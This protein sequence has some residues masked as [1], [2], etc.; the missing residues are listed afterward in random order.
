[1]ITHEKS[2]NFPNGQQKN[3]NYPLRALIALTA[4]VLLVSYV[5]T[6]VLPGIPIIEKDLSTTITIG[7]WITAIVLLVGAVVSPI[8]GK[9]GDIYGKKKLIIVTIA[10]YTVGVSIAGFSTSIYFLLF[11]RA[12]QGVGLAMIPLS[13][14]LVTDLFPK[15]KLATAQGAIAG[16]AAISTALGLVLGAY[17]VQDLGWQYAFH[18][19]AILSV[20]L[21][22]VVIFALRSDAAGAKCKIDYVGAFL[23][24][25]GVAFILL[26]TTE[27]STLGW[28][29]LEELA[30]LMPGL[31]LTISFFAFESKTTEPLI[32]LN[33]LRI[34]NVLIANL[35]TIM[36]GLGNFLLFFSVLEYLEFPKPFGLGFDI[37][38]CGLTI[39]PGTIVMFIVGPIAGRLVTKTGPKNV[40]ITG[41]I[42]SILSYLLLIFNRGTAIDV[43]IN[44]MVAFAGLV[45]LFVPLVNMI[46]VSLPK[47]SVTVGQGLNL[48]L[49][50]IGS[51]VGPILTTT[52]LATY[53]DPIVK[54]TSGKSIIVGSAPSATAFNVVFAIGIALSIVCIA[55]SLAIKN[56][57]S[58]NRT[59]GEARMRSS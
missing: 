54:V 20:I 37:I 28:L 26:Y 40:L 53:T 8:F 1:M 3:D 9:L 58:K 23:L 24:S 6:M 32:R 29:S 43:T 44:V 41:A 7:S 12:I 14:A 55:L 21:F 49:K 47:E 15:E 34:R 17:V 45:S 10:F 31:A 51:A 38:T 48:T 4:T 39:A 56:G 16:S 50:Q 19:A 42:I 46:S 30:F 5:E 18:T 25:L 33:L 57:A 35:V 27:G 22:V 36:S 13:L 52:I 59:Q 2:H 11:A